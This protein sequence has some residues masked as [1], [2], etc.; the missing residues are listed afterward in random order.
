MPFHFSLLMP[1]AGS[2]PQ[3][4]HDDGCICPMFAEYFGN[5]LLHSIFLVTTE[6]LF[7][8]AS[9]LNLREICKFWSVSMVL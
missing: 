5:Y 1:Y 4:G 7:S 3:I 8:L 9:R 2:R 6:M